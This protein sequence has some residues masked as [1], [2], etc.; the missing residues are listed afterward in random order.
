[1]CTHGVIIK[2]TPYPTKA[3]RKY[4]HIR[5]N[6]NLHYRQY[7]HSLTNTF[8][9]RHM[10]N[11]VVTT[12]IKVWMWI[13]TAYFY[14][15]RIHLKCRRQWMVLFLHENKHHGNDIESFFLLS[16][17]GLTL[18]WRRIQLFWLH[19]NICTL[20]FSHFHATIFQISLHFHWVFMHIFMF[21]FI[22]SIIF[23]WFIYITVMITVIIY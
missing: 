6:D 16:L 11:Y 15:D 17:N 3:K 13:H 21:A 10:G 14:N 22:S 12:V 1:M 2:R 8:R 19:F 23:I 9:F 18:K 20:L 4:P 5:F 7:T